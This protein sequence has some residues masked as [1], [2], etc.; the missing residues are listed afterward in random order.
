[1]TLRTVHRLTAREVEVARLLADGLSNDELAA[2]LRTSPNTARRHTQSVLS[3]LNVTS[4]ARVG[5]VLR[6]ES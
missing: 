5:A 1:E 2:R 3:K 4:R 6:A